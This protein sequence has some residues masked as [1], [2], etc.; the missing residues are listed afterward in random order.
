MAN[1]DLKD[2][3]LE[4]EKKFGK[5]AMMVG[6]EFDSNVP[7]ICSFGSIG[8][9]LAVGCGGVPEERFIQISGP[10]SSG[11]TT[12]ALHII[13]EAQKTRPDK[14]VGFI[15]AE[16]ALDKSWAAKLGVDT[17]KLV[18]S[19]PETG[20]EAF[21]LLEMMVKSK[22][23]SVIVLDSIAALITQAQLEGEYGQ[24]HMAQLARLTSS[25][26]PKLNVAMKDSGTT[27]V[28][29]NQLRTN[30]GGYGNPEV[31]PGG[32]A[33]KFYSS[34]ILDT[35]RREVIGDKENPT[36]FS[37]DF[38][39]A[40]NKCGAPFKIA[41]VD[42]YIGPE[43]FGVDTFSEVIDIAVENGIINKGGAWYKYTINGNEERWQG[44]PNLVQ[45]LKNNSDV[46][47]EIENL[48]YSTVLKKEKPIAG[49]FAAT[50]QEEQAD[51][52]ER[53]RMSKKEREANFE[54][55]KL[56]TPTVTSEVTPTE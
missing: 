34:I 11:K 28:L 17:E 44:K 12:L 50:I 5:N 52:P 19:Q 42:L 1:V 30:I 51:K 22:L 25:G 15:D 48:V 24:A 27:I 53:K 23:F 36:G 29:L 8:L 7:I 43:T 6:D 14:V 49:S 9:D 47:Q 31:R 18:I 45:F 41:K 39:V 3:F 38:K 35:R 2:L 33:P 26:F 32:N 16:L 13:R 55:T 40:K 56:I 54:E 4:A 37:T 46:Y 21:T 10:E 20:E